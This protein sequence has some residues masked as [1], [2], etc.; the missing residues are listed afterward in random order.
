M[1]CMA[2]GDIGRRVG[3]AME[4]AKMKPADLRRASEDRLSFARIGNWLR[5]D[6]DPKQSELADVARWVKATVGELLGDEPM[7]ALS[8]PVNVRPVSDTH[9]PNLGRISAGR[10]SEPNDRGD[11][12]LVPAFM[13]GP[14]RFKI[15]IEDDSMYPFLCPGDEAIF[16]RHPRPK[17][18]RAVKPARNEE[19]LMTIKASGTPARSTYYSQRT[20]I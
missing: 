15:E 18:G 19:G 7:R 14:G 8:D 20:L 11:T 17:L 6:N 12:A 4:R 2:S 5:G 9:I 3:K 16:Q 10:W 13:A 1:L